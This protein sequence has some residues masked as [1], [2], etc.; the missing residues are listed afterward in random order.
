MVISIL[1]IF[2]GLFNTPIF[3]T[4]QQTS[5]AIRSQTVMFMM[6]MYFTMDLLYNV[7]L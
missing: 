3:C 6:P 5:I 7:E 2:P 4:N 1:G